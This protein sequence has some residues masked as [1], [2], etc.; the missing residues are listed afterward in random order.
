[1]NYRLDK[2][3]N[4]ISILGYG[5]ISRKEGVYS[6]DVRVGE[7]SAKHYGLNSAVKRKDKIMLLAEAI[8]C[9]K[10]LVVH[11]AD[12]V[13]HDREAI[14]VKAQLIAKLIDIRGKIFGGVV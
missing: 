3:G 9:Q 1:M 2:Q 11:L 4:P 5:C 6:R 10:Q 13:G 7:S 14:Y 12:A 8:V